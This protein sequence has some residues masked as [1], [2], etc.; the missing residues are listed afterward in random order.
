MTE[1]PSSVPILVVEDESD[2]RTL[3]G[4]NLGRE[5]YEVE[6]TADLRSARRVLQVSR[7]HLIILDLMLPDGS[8]LELARQIRDNPSLS[9][10]PILFVTAQARE[11]ELKSYTFSARDDYLPKPFSIREL[12]RRVGNQVRSQAGATAPNGLIS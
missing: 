11:D 8:G 7:P 1:Q 4:Y 6:L 3:I 10:V 9:D 2:I 5:G 12:L